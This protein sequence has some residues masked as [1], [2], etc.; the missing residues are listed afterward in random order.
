MKFILLSVMGLPMYTL[1]PFM[2][3]GGVL[4]EGISHDKTSVY[5]ME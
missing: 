3:I 5:S 4:L 1:V 2:E